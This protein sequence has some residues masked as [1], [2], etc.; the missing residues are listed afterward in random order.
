MQQLADLDLHHLPWNE[1]SFAA[2]PYPH[3]AAARKKHPW[4]AKSDAGYVVFEYNAI[5]DL[6][7]QDDKMRASFDGIVELMG[8][9]GTP[10]GR[11]TEEQMLA[12][13]AREHRVLRDTFA[14]R[15]TPR[16]ANSVRPLMRETLNRLIDEQATG[17]S[18]DFEEFS[19]YYPVSVMAQL[20]GAPVSAIPDLRKSLETMGLAFSL[21]QSLVPALQEAVAHIDTFCQ[22]LIDERRSHPHEAGSEPDLLDILLEASREG[23]ISDR[24]LTDLLIF[25]FVAGY[26]TSKNVFTYLMHLLIEHPDIYRRCGEDIEYCRK[27]VEEGLRYFN[28]SSSFRFTDADIEYR[29]VLLP[30]DTM[31]F[32]TLN[33]SGRDPTVFEDADR[34]DPDRPVDP[35]KRQIAFG[36]GKHM[37]LGQ[38][39]ARAQLQEGLHMV[40]QRIR[41]PRVA[42]DIAWRPFPGVWGM[43]SLPIAFEPAQLEPA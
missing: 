33:M 25:L 31:L 9:K 8:A 22:G 7:L 19:S 37:C 39:I 29:G 26:D 35:K 10:W 5:R 12:L 41:Q 21:D 32:F 34:F 20:I 6:M 15:F 24:Q 38:Y 16:F 42:G 1:P 3:F 14:A 28:P 18:L 11:F 4:I 36:L 30:K 13:P 17:G 43:K 27:V 2:D 40:A 23:G